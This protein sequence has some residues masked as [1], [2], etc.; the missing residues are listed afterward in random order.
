MA[1]TET[2]S[3]SWFQ[4][5]RESFGGVL[6]GII[7]IVIGTWLLWWNEERTFKTAGAIGEAELVAQDVQ[8]ISRLDPSLEGKVIHAM[9]RADTK[10]IIRDDLFGVSV[11]AI[12]LERKAEYYQWVEHERRET[13]KKLGG[14]E[15]T[16]TTYTYRSEWTN[17]PVDSQNFK[18]SS[19]R[20]KNTIIAK[21]EDMNVWAQNVT[22]GAYT[23]SDSLKHGIGG[24][25]PMTLESVD[26]NSLAGIV[27]VR[28]SETLKKLITVSGSTVY[29]GRNPSSP[30]IGDVRVTFRQTPP[31]DVSI[32]AQVL[33]NTFEDYRA[34]NGYTFSRLAMGSVG[35]RAMFDSARSENTFMAWVLR[36]VGILCVCFGINLIFKP[37]SVIADVIPFLGTIIGAGAGFVSFVLG[38]A[39][40]LVVIAVAW[41]RFRPLIAICLIAAAL[42][43]IAI[44]YMKGRKAS[45]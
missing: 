33:R 42:A 41:L 28:K 44:S 31:A 43:L 32:I 11:N 14:G 37:L 34:S 19:Y 8:D 2:T 26:M 7:L 1:Y 21:I 12:K 22:F 39:W 25:Q 16:V 24:A 27:R 17:E 15:E 30:Q 40:S 36:I 6:T 20:D 38:F 29:I 4:R 45:V 13:R 5:V 18:D 9:G 3:K 23:L 10:D 35:M